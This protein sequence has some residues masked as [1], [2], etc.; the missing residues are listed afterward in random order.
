MGLRI[1]HLSFSSSGGAGTVAQRL[2]ATQ[3]SLGHSAHLVS[4]LSS[5]LKK[6][7]L[8]SPKHTLAASV[9]EYVVKQSTF[10]SSISLYREGL[11]ESIKAATREADVLHLHWP[12]GVVDWQELVSSTRQAVVWTLHDMRAFTGACHYSLDCEGYRTG[13]ANCPA[14]RAPWASKVSSQFTSQDLTMKAMGSRLQ[15]VSPS[16]WLAQ[17]AKSSRLLANHPV[18]VIPNPLPHDV[19]PS[20][21]IH[22]ETFSQLPE[23]ASVFVAAAADISDPVKDIALAVDAFSEAVGQDD[24]TWLFIAGAGN[25]SVHPHPRVCYLGH[26]T[27]NQMASL[28][29]RA[30]YLVVPSR[31]ENQPLLI[32]EAQSHGVSI[33]VRDATGL[34]EHTDIDPG[35]KTFR[36]L[37]DLRQLIADRAEAMPSERSRNSLAKAARQKFDPVTSA[38]RYLEI[39]SRALGQ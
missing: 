35:A 23:S 18:A 8:R 21:D 20:E 27:P 17:M 15:F 10:H 32:S 26:L 16:I 2:A 28:L 25:H 30:N 5:T 7:P 3:N 39:Y 1:T 37:S 29:A 31:A 34:P 38:S 6:Q 9:D 24:D 33:L 4:L 13:C 12:H 11:H 36:S 14:V 22:L 19:G